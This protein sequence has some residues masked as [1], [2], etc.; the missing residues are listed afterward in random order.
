M[1][2]YRVT[3]P[4]DREPLGEKVWRVLANH[5]YFLIMVIVALLLFFLAKNTITHFAHNAPGSAVVMGTN[6]EPSAAQTKARLRLDRVSIPEQPADTVEP[7]TSVQQPRRPGLSSEFAAEVAKQQLADRQ[8]EIALRREQVDLDKRRLALEEKKQADAHALAM[9][10]LDDAKAAREAQ[11]LADAAAQARLDADVAQ[12]A[13]GTL[14]PYAVEQRGQAMSTLEQLG[15]DAAPKPA[16]KETPIKSYSN[17]SHWTRDKQTAVDTEREGALVATRSKVHPCYVLR[18]GYVFYVSHPQ[19]DTSA[20]E[21]MTARLSHDLRAHRGCP[22]LIPKASAVLGSVGAV[23]AGSER[24]RL[25]YHR[26]L[27]NPSG[28]NVPLDAVAVGYMGQGGV[29]AVKD[30]RMWRALFN[31]LVNVGTSAV[32]VAAS[33]GGT[34]GAVVDA[35]AD[36]AAEQTNAVTPRFTLHPDRVYVAVRLKQDVFFDDLRPS[37]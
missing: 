3:Q 7:A 28:L 5:K 34:I 14:P 23:N 6:A 11:R 2:D 17:S 26:I 25:S 15:L 4:R 24:I 12:R 29:D 20:P 22:T 30:S 1:R 31:R 9:R 37:S 27:H 32:S 8:A 13:S 33:D 10:Q 35:G 21:D 16:P 19:V 36:T 18:E